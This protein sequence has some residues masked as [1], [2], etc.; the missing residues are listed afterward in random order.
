MAKPSPRLRL[1]TRCCD[2]IATVAQ[3]EKLYAHDRKITYATFA[4]H[5]DVQHL[6]LLLGYTFG[7][8]KRAGLRL[9]DDYAVT[10]YRSKFRGKV[11]YHLDWSR[12]DHIFISSE[13]VRALQQED[14]QHAPH[15]E[16]SE[17]DS[18]AFCYA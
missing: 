18:P 6:S 8:G 13:D 4:R 3:L 7:Q 11:C 5:V 15:S 1:F 10:F 9:A 17:S 12:I 14:S 2:Y 16:Q